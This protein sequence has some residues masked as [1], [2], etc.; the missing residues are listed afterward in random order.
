MKELVRVFLVEGM[1]ILQELERD[2]FE[3]ERNPEDME[4]TKKIFRGI[5]T[6]K[7]SAGLVGIESI[8][9]IAH[10]LEDMIDDVNN[11][12][13]ILG[14]DFFNV[15]M[16]SLEMMN[17]L[18]H[19]I[20]LERQFSISEKTPFKIL[21]I[22]LSLK[23]PFHKIN[24]EPLYIIERLKDKGL[25]SEV[26]INIS[27]VPLLDEINPLDNYMS[28]VVFLE[29]RCTENEMKEFVNSFTCGF[30][31][32]ILD[33]TE[34]YINDHII[35]EKLT[36][37][38]LIEHGVIDENYLQETLQGRKKIGEIL[39]ENAAAAPAQIESILEIQQRARKQEE[40][41]TF[42][43]EVKQYEKIVRISEQIGSTQRRFREL[44]LQQKIEDK[45]LLGI[46]DEVEDTIKNL[47]AEVRRT[48]YGSIREVFARCCYMVETIAR[49][50]GK[51]IDFSTVE[52]E[53]QIDKGIIYI[54]SDV[55]KHLVRNSADHGIEPPEE[56][57][58][59]GKARMGCISLKAYHADQYL[60]I[61][62]KD[63][64]RGLDAE[65][66]REKAQEKG[67]LKKRQALKEGEMYQ[68]I[69]QPGFST[70][71]QISYVS[72]RGMGLD[73]VYNKIKGIDGSIQI[74]SVPDVGVQFIFKIPQVNYNLLC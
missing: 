2:L 23:G 24:P 61:E 60:V 4:L 40:L 45:D 6:I 33:V 59:K 26:N 48:R 54:I 65:K 68:F 1:E 63:D 20:A 69:L 50:C 73:V 42:R 7:G 67:L 29:T 9:S 18:F 49:E 37:E 36:G 16:S 62:Y 11:S 31:V 71:S 55:L 39:V 15:M 58:A 22:S 38:L 43:I 5:H 17:H 25:L 34:S 53:A 30:G 70:A 51:E 3:L 74:K 21:R 44:V 52:Q 19:G 10:R 47:Q 56:R 57:M 28:W 14:P 8:N 12:G 66:I 72:G 46:L 64:G 13:A 41:E 35:A 27:R 32:K